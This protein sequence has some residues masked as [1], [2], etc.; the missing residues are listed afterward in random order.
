MIKYTDSHVPSYSSAIEGVYFDAHSD[1]MYIIYIGGRTYRYDNV[2]YSDFEKIAEHASPGKA[3]DDFKR[4]FIGKSTSIGCLW[5]NDFE[6]VEENVVAFPTVKMKSNSN[7]LKSDAGLQGGSLTML[8]SKNLTMAASTM[9]YEVEFRTDITGDRVF[10]H[11]TK[12]T[13]IEDAISKLSII[14]DALESVLTI[15]SVKVNYERN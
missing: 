8:S 4:T 5:A 12:A 6:H 14:S 11:Y 13:S 1:K 3:V 7:K 2:D 10:T 9:S 15:L